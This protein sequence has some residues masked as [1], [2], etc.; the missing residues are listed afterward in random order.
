MHIFFSGIGGTGIGPLAL[1]AKEAGYEV[2]GSDKQDSQYIKYLAA[3]GITNVHIGQTEEAFAAANAKKPVD[4]YVYSSA[5]PKENPNHPE[6]LYVQSNGIKHSKRD[7]F[8]NQILRDKKLKLVAIAGT[9]G[10]TTTTAMTVWLFKELKIPIS[11]SVGAK[12]ASGDMGQF[13][14]ASEYFVYECD[15]FDRNF[16]AFHP[17]ISLI[18]GIAW[19]HH[20]VFPTLED[21]QEAFRQFMSQSSANIVWQ[22]DMDV[23]TIHMGQKDTVLDY[24]DRELHAITLDGL[25]NRRNAWQAVKA[26]HQLTH[27]PQDKLIEIIN[28]FPGLSRRMERI[29]P[30]LYTDYAHTPEKV[31]GGIN[32]ALELA[33]PGEQKVVVVYEPLTNRRMHYTRDKHAKIFEG[34]ARIYWVPSYLAR[35]DPNLPILSPKELIQ[36][37]DPDL[38]ELAEPHKL[39]ETLKKAIQKHLKDGDL[40]VGMSGGGGN[41]LDEWLRREF[42]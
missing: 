34:A 16:L 1:I 36:S 13:D 41:S 39:N 2:S 30:N 35:E 8:L 11:F 28:T 29:I 14:P 19:D 22:A 37:L 25:Y 26:V 33:K 15:E 31:V 40:V 21:Y 23:A 24:E 42:K 6:L 17:C 7:E 38:Q 12:T 20:E 27:E 3:H 10:K 32:T 4:W 18:T 9:H 5:L